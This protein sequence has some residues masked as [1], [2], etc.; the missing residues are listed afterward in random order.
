MI[1]NYGRFTIMVPCDYLMQ[2]NNIIWLKNTLDT[3][4]R[5]QFVIQFLLFYSLAN[6]RF[7]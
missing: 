3:Y 5:L 4:I 2:V 1:I 7:I 6:V